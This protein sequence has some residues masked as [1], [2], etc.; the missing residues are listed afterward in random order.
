MIVQ[1]KIFNETVELTPNNT[2]GAAGDT[3]SRRT[4]DGFI[5]TGNNGEFGVGF[6]PKGVDDEIKSY[7]YR[8]IKQKLFKKNKKYH[9]DED[10]KEI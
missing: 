10:D 6:T 1:F 4:A 8:K 2:T 5:R 7:K 9:N 3:S